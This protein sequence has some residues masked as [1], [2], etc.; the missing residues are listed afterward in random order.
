MNVTNFGCFQLTYGSDNSVRDC[1]LRLYGHVAR[2]PVEDPAHRILFR[3]DP[4]GWFIPEGRPH[5]YWL[6]QVESNLKDT[7]MVGLASDAATRC[8]GVCRHT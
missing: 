4:R 6:R 1:K 2:L 5:A 8:S 3:R 7:G